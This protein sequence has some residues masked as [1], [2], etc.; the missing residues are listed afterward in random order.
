MS[1]APR[2]RYGFAYGALE[3]E[4]ARVVTL[5]VTNTIADAW[6][7]NRGAESWK[8]QY[9]TTYAGMF[10]DYYTTDGYTRRV[11]LGMGIMNPKRTSPRPLWG[12]ATKP[13]AFVVLGDLVHQST[14]TTFT[15]DLA[16]WA[17]AGWTGRC[18]LTAGVGNLYP[19]R[20]VLAEIVDVADSPE[21]KTVLEGEDLGGLYKLK[22]YRIVR[23]DT[24][25]GI[26]GR[27]DDKAWKSAQTAT[28]F[29][30]L[31]R[32]A[33]GEQTTTA[34]MTYDSDTL[35][36][37][38]DC[39][40]TGRGINVSS[41]K[42]W[43]RD[44][45]DIALNPSGD[46]ETFLQIIAD[47]AGNFDQFSHRLDGSTFRWD[48]IRVAAGTRDDGYSVEMAIPLESMGLKPEKGT[49]WVGNFVRYRASD[50]MTTWS[51]MPG[52]AIND[53]ERMAVFVLE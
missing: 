1:A 34:R 17:P 20:G 39:A 53:P 49:K 5:R 32:S 16:R 22:T 40:E 48:A 36:I 2:S 28:D 30:V 38:F 21:G 11:A 15:L 4:N 9:T 6:T 26:D 42:L 29:Y 10:V 27:L 12:A 8:P 44:A 52:P 18:W 14:E 45:V 47:A 23:T 3:L 37:A 51:F 25:P 33:V 41:E 31:G 7:F 13:D 50:P 19:G 24:P 35:Y 43:G 46:R